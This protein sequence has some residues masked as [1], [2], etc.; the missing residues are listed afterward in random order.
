MP[1]WIALL[2]AINVGGRNMVSMPQLRKALEADGFADVRSYVQSGNIVVRSSRR[3]AN[4]VGKQIGGLIEREFGFAVPVVMR[5][6]GELAEVIEANPFPDAAAERPKLLH[7]TFLDTDPDA[8][9]VDAIHSDDLTR[10]VCRVIGRQLYVDYV[11]GVH[12]SKL[13]LPYFS[14]RLGVDGTARNWRTVLALAE[15][16]R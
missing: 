5:T 12:G 4:S 10:D 8:D 11:D 9:G 6:P 14:R 1:T 3:S 13:T 2:R 16:S 15:L 7:V